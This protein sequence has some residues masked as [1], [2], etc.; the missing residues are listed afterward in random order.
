VRHR[1]LIDF[2]VALAALAAISPA[3]GWI[4]AGHILRPLRTITATVRDISATGLHRRLAL[5]SPD[6]ELKELGDTFDGL[7]ARLES[8][9][10]A[11]RRFV[12][13]ASLELRT[14]LSRQRALGR[15][16]LA[17]PAAG[18]RTLRAA[19]ERI[20]AAGAQQERLV[21]ALLTLTRG[22]A[23]IDV[24]EP[25]DLAHVTDGVVTARRADAETRSV[26]LR[27]ASSPALAA[28]H[29]GLAERLVAN[30][31]D[32]ALR[33]NRP[34]GWAEVTTG[35]AGGSA[36]LTV[37]NSGPAVSPDGVDDLF[38]PFHRLG[39]TE[40][41]EGPGL[42][43]SIVRA[44]AGAHDATVTATARPEGG[45]TVEVAFPCVSTRLHALTPPAKRPPRV[46][47]EA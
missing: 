36:T 26:A 5:P 35:T 45:L 27:R 29:R 21:E 41:A 38:Q 14:P 33:H 3:L 16:A 12:A 39:G 6:D 34:G 42:G 18:T 40:A 2:A 11:Q 19:H 22:Q 10:E 15:A 46:R 43:L 17:D 31:V 24:H 1:L 13:N 44:I 20:L 37:S 25:F 32:N 47:D 9:F 30:L 4:V 8:A 23:A 28:G 7:L